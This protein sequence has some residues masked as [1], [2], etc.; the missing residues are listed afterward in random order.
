MSHAFI[1]SK[2]RGAL[3]LCR[4]LA[5][6]GGGLVS[7]AC[8]VGLSAFAF[9]VRGPPSYLRGLHFCV[10][11]A[12]WDSPPKGVVSPFP[13]RFLS[14]GRGIDVQEIPLYYYCFFCLLH[15]FVSGLN[16]F[17]HCFQILYFIHCFPIPPSE[18]ACGGSAADAQVANPCPGP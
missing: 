10:N 3:L 14:P 4:W 18:V 11:F 5:A 6:E 2:I 17:K 9:A 13:I 15:T 16:F 7:G 8:P 12:P 1:L